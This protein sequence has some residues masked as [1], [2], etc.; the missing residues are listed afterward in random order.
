[1]KT[2]EAYNNSNESLGG[3]SKTAASNPDIAYGTSNC[4]GATYV[5]DLKYFEAIH[6]VDSQV[7]K[8][9][10]EATNERDATLMCKKLG[11]GLVGE[12]AQIEAQANAPKVEYYDSAVSRKLLG[13]I[14]RSTL[15]KELVLGNLT[16][17]TGT[18]K[19]LITADSIKKWRR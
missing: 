3:N 19:I 18:R 15:H 16:R 5:P 17:A 8:V 10:F 11:L 1:M 14:S 7:R 6:I 12:T 2:S 4:N 9:R 13:G